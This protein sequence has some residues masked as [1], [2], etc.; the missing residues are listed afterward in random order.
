MNP[1]M[2]TITGTIAGLI[3]GIIAIFLVQS[4]NNSLYPP[5]PGLDPRK[6]EDLKMLM[7]NIPVGALLIVLLA[8]VVGSFVGGA[9]ATMVARPLRTAALT[10][11]ALLTVLGIWNLAS[12]PHPLWFWVTIFVYIPSALMGAGLVLRSG[13]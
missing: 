8:Y 9:I 3:A 12:L 2:K 5:P 11:G 7:Q 13:R 4:I 1:L 10:T 6:P